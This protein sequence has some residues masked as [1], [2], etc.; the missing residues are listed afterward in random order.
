MNHVTL[1]RGER[2]NSWAYDVT[3]FG[4]SLPVYREAPS[5]WRAWESA[6]SQ[7]DHNTLEVVIFIEFK[8]E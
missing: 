4:R 5:F 6:I 1:Y 8:K 3:N 2:P 7:F